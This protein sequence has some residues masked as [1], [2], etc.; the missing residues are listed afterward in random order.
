LSTAPPPILGDLSSFTPAITAPVL[1]SVWRRIAAAIVD[2]IFITIP[3]ALIAALLFEP[4]THLGSLGPLLGFLIALPYF[5]HFN[6]GR[7]GGQTPGKR[8]C[9]IRIVDANGNFLSVEK[10]ALR[11]TIWLL[12]MTLGSIALPISRTPW[13]ISFLI[14]VISLGIGGSTLYLL[15]F[16]RH[17]R[18][19]VHDLVVGSYVVNGVHEGPVHLQPIWKPHRIIIGL[20]FVALI[21]A[22]VLLEPKLMKSKTF[23]HMFE[24]IKLIEAIP[25]VQNAGIQEMRNLT[26]PGDRRS[27]IVN[28]VW[29][30]D[31]ANQEILAD[32]I[33]GIVLENDPTTDNDKMLSIV[34]VRGYDL[35][36]LHYQV[37][38]SFAHSPAEWDSM[39]P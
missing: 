1:G 23:A 2:V 29:T 22:E 28:V 16:N 15:F 8:G 34:I 30:G 6:S 14:S 5:T 7:G 35:G 33:A 32:R 21:G 31:S 37:S 3:C 26:N 17:T 24:D 9:N 12:P 10:A 4:L 36:F 11:Y 18:Q 27:L 39:L 25:G 13:I 19:T 38:Q 20:F